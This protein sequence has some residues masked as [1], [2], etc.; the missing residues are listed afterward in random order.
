MTIKQCERGHFYDENK[1]DECPYCNRIPIQDSGESPP[2]HP[3]SYPYN[4][5]PTPP[6]PVYAGPPLRDFDSKPVPTPSRERFPTVAIVAIAVAGTILLAAL[7]YLV[8]S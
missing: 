5:F 4:A 6:A 7:L 1:Y 3:T 2:M 8:F